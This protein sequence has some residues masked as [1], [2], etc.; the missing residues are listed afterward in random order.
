MADSKVLSDIIKQQRQL[1]GIDMEAYALCFA[2]ENAIKPKPKYFVVKSVSDFA[3]A[4]K[5]DK[6]RKYAAYVSVEVVKQY[7]KRFAE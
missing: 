6:Y 4:E 5:S 1:L 7:F 2:G 3:D